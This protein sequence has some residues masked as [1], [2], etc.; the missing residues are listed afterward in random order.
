MNKKLI[1]VMMGA[2]IMASIVAM[3]VQASLA[4]KEQPAQTAPVGIEILIAGRDLNK[5][6]VLKPQD[7]QW[8]R[9]NKETVFAGIVKK[10]EDSAKKEVKV[11][12]KTLKRD[13]VLGE[14]IT[15]QS[16]IMD[17]EGAAT[18]L[19]AK[20]T[21]GMRAVAIKVKADTSAGG[22][23]TPGD[24]VDIILTYQ[25]RL[26]GE[27][28]QYS[29]D[30]IQRFASETIMKNIKVL[31]V[32]QDSKEK[33]REAKVARTVTLEVTASQAQ[34]LSMASQM[35]ELTLALRR[36]GDNSSDKDLS[37]TTDVYGS[38]VINDIY[39]KMYKTKLKTGSV[40]VYSGNQVQDMPV[41]SISSD[42]ID[43]GGN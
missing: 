8:K 38:R 10:P 28:A 14:P 42:L 6:E 32:D 23:V 21:T 16:I 26:Q 36:I 31:A 4:P 3:L 1:I 20:I 27:V 25:L 39:Q 40:R 19:S 43:G 33:S 18:G 34:S 35:G 24:N 29:Q 17:I 15:T 11:F 7:T 9:F 12:N 30:T 41:N 5:G 13:L 37:S 2:F 22:F